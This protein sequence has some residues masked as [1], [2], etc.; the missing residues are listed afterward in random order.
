MACSLAAQ[1]QT[2]VVPDNIEY[3]VLKTLYETM[4]GTGWTRKT[5]WPTAGAWPATATSAQF[6]TWAGVTVANGDI[7]ILNLGN[8]NVI[9]SI[10]AAI[11]DLRAVN[12]LTFTGNL[13]ITGSLPAGLGTLPN[14]LVL[15]INS[16]SLSGPLPGD[17]FLAPKL[18]NVVANTNQLSGPLPET[19]PLC[20]TLETLYLNANQLTGNIPEG[21]ANLTKLKQLRLD[22]NQLTGN[23]PPLGTLTDLVG[24]YLGI[25][26]L[27]GEIP[28]LHTLT[29]LQIL[30]LSGLPALSPA[31]IPAWLT[32]MTELRRVFLLNTRRIGTLPEDLGDLYKLVDFSAQTNSLTGKIPESIGSLTSLETLYLFDNKLSGTVPASIGNL[33][34]LE[35]LYLQN[36]QLEGALPPSVA[37]LAAL[38]TVII[39]NNR[40]TGTFPEINA[41]PF[42]KTLTLNKN[43]FTGQ[44]PNAGGCI[45]LQTVMASDNAFTSVHPGIINLAAPTS[46]AFAQNAL[47]SF[48]DFS[49]VPMDRSRLAINVINNY[50]DFTQLEPNVGLGWR[51]FSPSPMYAIPDVTT[52]ALQ[53]GQPLMITARPV[54]Q[55]TTVSWEK[56][57]TDKS[58]SAINTDQD[59]NPQT[60]TRTSATRDDE[61]TY[62]WKMTSAKVGT[63]TL[64][65][66]GIAVKIAQRFTLDDLAFQY[67]Y[68][69]RKRMIAKKAPGADWVY[70]VY[71]DRDR[72]VLTQ[73]GEQRKTKG[74]TFTKYDV[75]NRRIMTGTY[76][77]TDTSGQKSMAANISKTLLYETYTNDAGNH[78]YSNTVFPILS[79][80]NAEVM[81]VTYYDNY[82][83]VNSDGRYAYVP[84]DVEGQ[85]RY[86]NG[87]TSF[88]R[89]VGQMTGTRTKVL[90]TE[91]YWLQAVHYYDDKYRIIQSI[92]DNYQEGADRVTH[93]YDFEGRVLCT[94][95]AQ[96][97]GKVTWQNVVNAVELS[98]KLQKV[99]ATSTASG[100]AS[101]VQQIATGVNG[102]A[103]MSATD[104]NKVR[105]FGL[106]DAD[107]DLTYASIDFGFYLNSNAALYVYE[108]GLSK[109]TVPG[110]YRAGDKLRIE[111]VGTQIAY[112]KNGI[113]VWT[114]TKTS[115]GALMM[116]I[117]LTTAGAAI[118]HA[119]MGTAQ[120]APVYVQQTHDYDAAGR[121]V[122][123]WHQ[124]GE[125]AAK[126]VLLLKKEY[127]ELGLLVDKKLHSTDQGES[128]KQS[129]DYR[130]NIRG[131]LTS[132]NN[133]ARNVSATNDD[134]G[135]LFGMELAYENSVE[136]IT[137]NGHA[138][139]N[140]NVSAMTYS[141]L[142]GLG[143]VEARGYDYTYD[144]LNRLHAATHHEK[145]GAWQTAAGFHEDN[146][147]YDLNGNIK[148]LDRR[149]EGGSVMDQLAY[150]YKGNTLLQV[151]DA[152][153]K[154][155]GFVDGLTA[156]DDYA[157][158][159]NGNMTLDNNKD[160]ATVTYNFLN[161]PD[162]VTK[163]NGE[164]VRYL[165]DAIG[166][167][168]RQEVYDA[169]SN[170][171]KWTDYAG[172][173][174]YENDTLVFMGHDEGRVVV[175]DTPA[176]PEY[177][178][179]LKDHLNN[180][181]VTF[182]GKTET[183]DVVATLEP[184]HEDTEQ[185]NFL[186][187]DEAIKVQSSWFDHTQTGQISVQ[188]NPPGDPP[189]PDEPGAE[190]YATRLMGGTQEKYGLAR[191]LQVMPGDII[192]AAVFAKYIDPDAA[193]TSPDLAGVLQ[194][195]HDKN[196]AI[197]IDG[198]LTGSIGNAT[199]PLWALFQKDD[200]GG[201]APKAYLNYILVDQNFETI[202]VGY[203][204]I[205]TDCRETGSGVPHDRL[206]FDGDEKIVVTRPGYLYVYISNESEGLVEVYFDDFQ[207]MHTK[208]PVV[209]LQDYYPFGLS[210]NAYLREDHMFNPYLY[211]KKELQDELALNW[212]DYGARMY[213]PEIGRWSVSD[214][215]AVNYN[216]KSPYHFSG[217]NPVRY[218]DV[219]GKYYVGSDGKE[220][221]LLLK[222]GI[223]KL[224][225]N[226]TPELKK[227]VKMV[228][229]SGSKT[230]IG[231]IVKAGLNETKIHVKIEKEV[232]DQEGQKGYGLLGV[233]QA[234]DKDGKE[235]V[236]NEKKNDF[237]G[238]PEYV[239]GKTGVYKEA[240]ITIFEGNIKKEFEDRGAA[241]GQY[242]GFKTI[243]EIQEMTATFQ[244]ETTHD[245]DTKF[246]QNLRD[247]REGK[248]KVKI[249]PHENVTPQERDVYQEMEDT[250]NGH[251]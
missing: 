86:D 236:W 157:Y 73:D 149:G 105:V 138:Q 242:W 207:V 28:D 153:E 11:Q 26:Q 45:R 19:L 90:G 224:G 121:I 163:K 209:Q 201:T 158:D 211:N 238:V 185:G 179:Y 152:G 14:L 135:D 4:G 114:S 58:W 156:G 228:N 54:G 197:F 229:A 113:R 247:R 69:S 161:L 6:G 25:N 186:Y 79:G 82:D 75:L 98:G 33:T 80:T 3:Q 130:Y 42:L 225:A 227:L 233:H 147:T 212:Y 136:G 200:D 15:N 111:R 128:F 106:S 210:F 171:K 66:A 216:D 123:V 126:K 31:P 246:I 93:V 100:G 110:N 67:K 91:S 214:P 191:S 250:N 177:Q 27:T 88:P 74:W 168:H 2:N 120:R 17:M 151:T 18:R 124:V 36:N 116:D 178:Y 222:N 160:V 83:F 249:D 188:D 184:E 55:F 215:L 95:T 8:N 159:A 206:A 70:L 134:A 122:N 221:E 64:Y 146:V 170:R 102:W 148:T 77:H 65:S 41:M 30:Y 235:L 226:A 143:N 109:Y 1:A 76:I 34:K 62:R 32:S 223:I 125:D 49:T 38:V 164:Y 217:N 194:N 237:D 115:T 59:S 150:R 202:D 96:T 167:K 195:I 37:N 12:T 162:R 61:G 155:N 192:T 181:R 239:E 43:G 112:Y 51:S 7:T 89:L 9:N 48:P 56:Q 81:T 176:D 40:F 166:R 232:H 174:V 22:D 23:I 21:V 47:T 13:G 85:Y 208:S 46:L 139:Y 234:H 172:D 44:F 39:S 127:N 108:D 97:T 203:K 230:A 193:P 87:P 101:S 119:R 245:T 196:A 72:V 60:Y 220:V 173:I 231:Q 63:L 129:M 99:G 132:I 84:N 107:P 251:K 29:K 53:E 52:V 248:T 20:T 24:L 104:V 199:L 140:G 145:T 175:K 5:N 190:G 219:D 244:H 92:A 180:V 35:T 218:R 241:N 118:G 187:Y 205:T 213:M 50:L 57:N 204:R 71:D 189:S 68:D 94:R 182:S 10:P 103:E 142:D 154:A 133:T 131:W 165:Y 78:G 141:S 243:T 117:S 144:V 169:A 137:G 183:D 198:G 240:T 16:C